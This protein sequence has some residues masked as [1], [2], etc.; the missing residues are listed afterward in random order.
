[1]PSFAAAASGGLNKGV[2]LG[3]GMGGLS[4]G[5]IGAGSGGFGGVGGGFG[6]MKFGSLGINDDVDADGYVFEVFLV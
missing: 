6:G 5:A 4:F 2:G 1:M 3:S